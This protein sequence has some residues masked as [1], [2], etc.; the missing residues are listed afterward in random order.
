MSMVRDPSVLRYRQAEARQAKEDLTM[1]SDDDVLT[2]Y[3]AQLHGL[4]EKITELKE[5]KRMHIQ[6]KSDM[7]RKKWEADLE[8]SE[9]DTANMTP[10]MELRLMHKL[11][12]RDRKRK[13]ASTEKALA[14]QA[15]AGQDPDQEMQTPL[16]GK[17]KKGKAEK[18]VWEDDWHGGGDNDDCDGTEGEKEEVQKKGGEVR[19]KKVE[20]LV[21]RVRRGRR[22]VRR[23]RRRVRRWQKKDAG[24]S[25]DS[26]KTATKKPQ[27]R[28]RRRRRRRRTRWR[29]GTRT[30]RRRKRRWAR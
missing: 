24:N 9:G 15:V 1:A 14:V 21:V 10:A 29:K 16:K 28:R 17:G 27:R 6:A 23:G 13:R 25:I 30:R 12:A 3:D 11:Q 4:A 26:A 8:I 20:A 5:Q 19:N 22:R 7:K 2:N 18:E